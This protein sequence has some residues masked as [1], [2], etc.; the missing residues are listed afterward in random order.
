MGGAMVVPILFT[1]PYHKEQMKLSF[2][3]DAD[4]FSLGFVYTF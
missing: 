2:A 4:S 3:N 1:T